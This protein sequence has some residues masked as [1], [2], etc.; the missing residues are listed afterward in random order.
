[1]TPNPIIDNPTNDCALDSSVFSWQIY[2]PVKY[3]TKNFMPLVTGTIVE[4]PSFVDANV[5]TNVTL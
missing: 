2:F 1:M 3:V 5:H 4:T